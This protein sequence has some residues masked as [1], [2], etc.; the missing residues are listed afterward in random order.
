M[1][2]SKLWLTFF[3]VA[4]LVFVTFTP[5]RADTPL[6]QGL[7]GE[8]P[9][10]GN[11]SLMPDDYVPPEGLMLTDATAPY[12]L[13]PI[14][15]VWTFNR[16]PRL[17][18]A[19]NELATAYKIYM[20]DVRTTQTLLYTF[21]GGT[22][23]CS[24]TYC[25]LKPPTKLKTYKYDEDTGGYYAWRVSARINGEWV[26]NSTYAYFLVFSKG[27]TSTFD[28]NTRGWEAVDGTWNRTPAGLYKTKG[29]W[30]TN[31]SAWNKEY[32]MENMVLEV[33]MK[34]KVEIGSASRI[35][36]FGEP[37]STWSLNLWDSGYNFLYYNNGNWELRKFVAGV[38]SVIDIG[39]TPYSKP[40]NW[41]TF[42]FWLNNG[43]IHIWVNDVW[44]GTFYDNSLIG[45][46]VGLGIYETN[47][48]VSPLLVDYVKVYYSGVY[49][50]V[51]PQEEIV[52]NAP[53]EAVLPNELIE[54]R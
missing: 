7:N 40:L 37:G 10:L 14:N 54:I 22:E 25:W 3:V 35:Y 31:V 12:P 42:K 33:R 2:G 52:L 45:G 41:N 53:D 20:Y 8:E 50:D 1:K 19:H 27:F 13:N 6:P 46:A 30:G 23:N 44:L 43:M 38:F 18:F 9:D 29:I 26:H 24:G 21:A 49:P 17:F 39:V 11:L 36:F 28:V 51:I 16:L 47:Q 34:R 4:M 15:G 5:A 48:D 32:F